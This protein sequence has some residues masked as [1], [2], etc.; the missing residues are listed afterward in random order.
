MTGERTETAENT[1]NTNEEITAGVDNNNN[2][3][4]EGDQLQQGSS[5]LSF[6][7]TPFRWI[8][9]VLRTA[10][11]A[12]VTIFG[13]GVGVGLILGDSLRTVAGVNPNLVGP[14]EGRTTSGEGSPSTTNGPS[15]PSS[16]SRGDNGTSSSIEN[17]SIQEPNPST[18]AALLPAQ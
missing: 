2:N 1:T 13:L 8:G 9:R 11:N 3:N 18:A 4:R 7:Y 16:R 10:M 17:A 15:C 5:R 12:A 14:E 6:V